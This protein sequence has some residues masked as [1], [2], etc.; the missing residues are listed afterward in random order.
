MRARWLRHVAGRVMVVGGLALAVVGA[1]SCGHL[2]S[3]GQSPSYLFI[4]TLTGA[5]G[6]KPDTFAN[7][8]QS[9]VITYVKTTVGGQDVPVATI[10]ED[11]GRVSLKMALKDVGGANAPTLPTSSNSITVTRYHVEYR[12]ADG[13]N[14]P[15]VDVPYPFDGGV[16]GTF[17]SNGNTMTFVIVRAQAKEEAPLSALRG[18]GGASLIS[19]IASVTFYG[20]DQNGNAVSVTGSMSVNFADWGDPA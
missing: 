5:S 10:F 17:D 6:A 16:T 12:R 18:G 19:T 15:G 13:R 3:N 20:Q 7:T 4:D 9:D 14:T 1:V 8:L 11:M 2:N